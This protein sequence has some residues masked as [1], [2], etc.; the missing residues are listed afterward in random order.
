MPQIRLTVEE[1]HQRLR[2]DV[3]LTK[4][5]PEAPSRT[6]L[7]KLIETGQVEVNG[8]L[9]KTHYKV[10]Q[11]DEIVVNWPEQ[12]IEEELQP[13][14]IPLDIFYEDPHLLVI[15]KPAGLLVHPVPGKNTGTLVN[16]LLHHS[17]TL[18]DVNSA[19][20]PG[21]VHR[22][23]RETSGL[24]CV[25]KD[26]VSH[27]RL[28]R[29]FEKHRIKKKY[30]ALVKGDVAFEEGIVDEALARHPQ[31]FDKRAVSY[32]ERQ[33]KAAK[34]MY[35]VLQRFSGKATLVALFPESGR[36]HQLRVHM[37]HIGHSIL[38]DEKYGEKGSFPRMA[39]HAQMLGFVH[40]QTRNYVEFCTIIP[41][42]FRNPAV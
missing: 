39:L 24:I 22:L 40:P 23:D 15:N 34:T 37:A 38:G 42:E 7:K 14:E 29:Q 33:S 13:E 5:L 27:A 9:V 21:I 10:E 25:A 17:K 35:R 11:D 6:F 28:A 1:E 20:R 31:Y 2:L 3:Y 12:E 18:S 16:A 8:Q 32:D 4:L 30:V 19:F 36:T 41:P 26:N